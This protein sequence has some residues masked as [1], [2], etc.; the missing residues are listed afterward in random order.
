MRKTVAKRKNWRCKA[1]VKQGQEECGALNEWWWD[2]CKE[3]GA[4]YYI[5]AYPQ[6]AENKE[7]DVK[8]EK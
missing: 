2:L 1:L 4:G 7:V 6:L 5:S 3:C 8:G